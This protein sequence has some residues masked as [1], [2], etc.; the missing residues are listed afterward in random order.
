M[1]QLK[2]NIV[3]GETEVQRKITW[4]RRH[5]NQYKTVLMSEQNKETEIKAWKNKINYI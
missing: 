3:F 4:K 1:L 2:L 5:F